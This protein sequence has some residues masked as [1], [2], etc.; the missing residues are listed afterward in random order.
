MK[1]RLAKAQVLVG[2]YYRLAAQQNDPR[3]ALGLGGL[4]VRG[5]GVPKDERQA[6]TLFRQASDAGSGA[7]AL[8]LAVMYEAGRGVPRDLNQALFFYRQA[9]AAGER[10]A[11]ADVAR[12]SRQ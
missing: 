4:Y 1:F 10:G 7:G 9:A 12:L 6:A 8:N 5:A 11:E 2:R 3:G